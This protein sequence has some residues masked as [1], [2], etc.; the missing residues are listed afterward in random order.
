MFQSSAQSVRV[1]LCPKLPRAERKRN[2]ELRCLLWAQWSYSFVWLDD[3][4][5]GRLYIQD[6]LHHTAPLV[7][8]LPLVILEFAWLCKTVL[9]FSFY[10]EKICNFTKKK[11]FSFLCLWQDS[12]QS[13]KPVDIFQRQLTVL[14][15]HRKKLAFPVPAIS[16][17]GSESSYCCCETGLGRM[18]LR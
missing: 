1:V 11:R 10:F 16:K 5:Q 7:L 12:H 8:Q 14:I 2:K 15:L 4:I 9:A 13:L 17:S 18:E 6:K 3:Y